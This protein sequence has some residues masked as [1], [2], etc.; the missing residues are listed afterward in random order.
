MWSGDLDIEVTEEDIIAARLAGATGTEL[1]AAAWHL[2]WATFPA[3]W[4]QHG[5]DVRV[6]VSRELKLC[7]KP[8][9]AGRH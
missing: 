3:R 7:T 9:R 5:A 4:L 1:L 6:L 2:S 8:A